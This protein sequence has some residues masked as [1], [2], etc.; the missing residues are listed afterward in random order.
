LFRSGAFRHAGRRQT[1]VIEINSLD[2]IHDSIFELAGAGVFARAGNTRRGQIRADRLSRHA[3]HRRGGLDIGLLRCACPRGFA[4]KPQQRWLVVRTDAG[5]VLHVE[6]APVFDRPANAR[7]PSLS[8]HVAGPLGD[9][10]GVPDH[11]A[12]DLPL[13]AGRAPQ[14][15]LRIAA[16]SSPPRQQAVYLSPEGTDFDYRTAPYSNAVIG[17]LA[18]PLS[19][20][21]S[22]RFDAVNAVELTVPAG[23]FESVSQSALLSGRNMLAVASG[24]GAW[25]VLQFRDADETASGQW[26]LT[27]LL[28]GQ[29]GTEDA[30]LA[31]ASIG[32]RAVLLN[33]AVIPAGLRA[34]EIGLSLNM[35]IGPAGR[36]FTDRYF[37]TVTVSGGLRA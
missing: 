24:N 19:G 21:F 1:P 26:R 2:Q 3:R 6:A 4:S 16:W 22:G 30:M 37:E 11:V 33:E 9:T 15:Q 7:I 36:P 10:A 32:A 28:R 8:A 35:R 34:H 17:T 31:G 29:G 14:D 27:H 5:D 20:G 23:A 13:L 18:A 12:L 25:E